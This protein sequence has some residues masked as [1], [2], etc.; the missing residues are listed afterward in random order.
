MYG[1][2]KVCRLGTGRYV[3]LPKHLANRVTEGT[4]WKV[5]RNPANTLV[6]KLIS[7][8]EYARV[9]TTRIRLRTSYDDQKWLRIP[10]AILRELDNK[11]AL[12]EEIIVTMNVDANEIELQPVNSR[13]EQSRQTSNQ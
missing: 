9:D 2:M 10:T 4:N 6:L 13:R 12:S 11:W 7:A 5:S 8:A 1:I 3:G